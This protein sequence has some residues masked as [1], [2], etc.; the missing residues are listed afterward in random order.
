[1]KW[2]IQF[3]CYNFIYSNVLCTSNL[4]HTSVSLADH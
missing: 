4:L 2:S 3:T 1:M